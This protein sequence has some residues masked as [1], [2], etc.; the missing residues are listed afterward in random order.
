MCLPYRCNQILQPDASGEGEGGGVRGGRGTPVKRRCCS[1]RRALR[2]AVFP[3]C[4]KSVYHIFP[5]HN[6]VQMKRFIAI[7]I[8]F[9]HM[10]VK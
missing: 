3:D 6:S 7:T 8:I 9:C 10:M 4:I 1:M 5:I 2:G